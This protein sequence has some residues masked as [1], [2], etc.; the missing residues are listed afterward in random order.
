MRLPEILSPSTEPADVEDETTVR[1]RRVVVVATLVVGA[2]LLGG[3]LAAPEGSGLLYVLGVLVAATWLGGSALSGPLHLGRR[4]GA[5]AGGRQVV[6]P[7]LLGIALFLAFAAAAL[8][9]RRIP[10]LADA[11]ERVLAKAD[12][13]PRGLVL[14]VALLNGV[15]EEVFFRGA[16]H[17]ALGRH[18][19]AVWA[20]ALYV[21][22]TVATLNLSL[23]VAAVVMGTVF[24]AERQATRGVLAPVVTHVA[25]STLVLFLLPR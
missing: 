20:T 21:L 17:S 2:A 11:V 8:L 18:R 4:G 9:A 15:A 1:R 12:A 13:G 3:T 7:L 19:P 6:A 10:F 22:V 23:V 5:E 24:T 16:V 25:W 14:A